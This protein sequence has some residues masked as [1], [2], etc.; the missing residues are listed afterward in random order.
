VQVRGVDP[1]DQQWEVDAPA[2]RVYFW[3]PWSK[4]WRSDEFEVTDADIDDVLEWA[5][6]RPGDHVSFTV[7]A[8]HQNEGRLGLIRLLG[9]DPTA[10]SPPPI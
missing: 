3:A 2:Y 8:C 6:S 1:R 4:G 9:R 7:Y 10:P 5:T